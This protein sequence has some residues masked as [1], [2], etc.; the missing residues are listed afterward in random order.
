MPKL[1]RLLQEQV[2]SSLLLLGIGAYAI[3]LFA[4]NDLDLYIHPRYIP[5]TFVAGII[6]VAVMTVSLHYALR[7]RSVTAHR[8]ARPGALTLLLIAILAVMW[9]VQPRPLLSSAVTQKQGAAR[10]MTQGRANPSPD[11]SGV[12]SSFCPPL[13]AI[14]PMTL[15]RWAMIM[16]GCFDVTA[17]AGEVVEVEGFAYSPADKQVPDGMMLLARFAISCCAIDATPV[18]MR[19]ETSRKFPSD[20]WLRIKGK[21]GVAQF[22][23]KERLT[24][25][26]QSIEQI[27][28]PEEPY[29]YW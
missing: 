1:R 3:K 17:Y 23:G 16:D 28:E 22:D 12:V 15:P 29:A 14:E 21:V 20:T 9:G 25:D 18:S 13:A 6:V 4:G 2:W 11:T 19:I 7:D 24:L 10:S 8:L 27:A 5:Y 26:A